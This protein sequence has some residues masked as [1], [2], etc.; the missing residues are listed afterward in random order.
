MVRTGDSCSNADGKGSGLARGVRKGIQVAALAAALVPLGSVPVTS[1]DQLIGAPRAAHGAPGDIRAD[2]GIPVDVAAQCDGAE[3]TSGT[4]LALV[5][6]G[7]AGFP[8]SRVLLVTSCVQAGEGGS[9]I[10]LFFTDPSRR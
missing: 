6:G 4:A 9:Q 1:T 10:K 7:K 2:V 8:A 5:P 3:G